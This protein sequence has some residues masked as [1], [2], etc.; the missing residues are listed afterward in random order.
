MIQLKLLSFCACVCVVTMV[1]SRISVVYFTLHGPVVSIT[2]HFCFRHETQ[3]SYHDTG[4]QT[5]IET[6]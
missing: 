5:V 3:P 1:Y 6:N 4:M 2:L